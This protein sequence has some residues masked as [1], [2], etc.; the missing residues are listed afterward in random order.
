MAAVSKSNI[1]SRSE[2]A[3]VIIQDA[4]NGFNLGGNKAND[5]LAQFVGSVDHSCFHVD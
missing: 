4:R 5:L 3:A 2:T 1:P